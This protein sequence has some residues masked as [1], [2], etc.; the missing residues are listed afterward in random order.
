MTKGNFLSKCWEIGYRTAVNGGAYVLPRKVDR[1]AFRA[2]FVDGRGTLARLQRRRQTRV[3]RP[4]HA[5]SQRTS[6]DAADLTGTEQPRNCRSG[7]PLAG[8]RSPPAFYFTSNRAG[9]L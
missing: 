4:A 8:G 3:P 1:V 9:V 6:E 5:S 7:A 2:G